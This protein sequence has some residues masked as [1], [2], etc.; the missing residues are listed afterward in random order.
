MNVHFLHSGW[1]G[2]TP[3]ANQTRVGLEVNWDPWWRSTE[4]HLFSSHQGLD[5]SSHQ[6]TWTI[7]LDRCTVLDLFESYCVGCEDTLRFQ[8]RRTYVDILGNVLCRS[9][10]LL[11]NHQHTWR[12]ALQVCWTERWFCWS[13]LSHFFA[14]SY[15]FRFVSSHRLGILPHVNVMIVRCCVQECW[16]GFH[17]P[18]RHRDLCELRLV[19]RD[20]H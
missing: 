15:P 18:D 14:I 9:V 20:R 3:R 11:E 2:L 12:F 1:I 6:G 5:E 19:G 8:W 16:R 4:V 17:S 10:G 7:P 13:W